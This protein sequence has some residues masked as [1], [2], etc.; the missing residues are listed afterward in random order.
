MK[1][2]LVLALIISFAGTNA[3]YAFKSEKTVLKAGTEQNVDKNDPKYNGKYKFKTEKI[4]PSQNKYEY[5]NMAWW[6]GF[7]DE[8]L[9]DVIKDFDD[10]G[11]ELSVDLS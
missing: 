2:I 7:N 10:L 8:Y 11:F 9:K 4:K 5:I 6:N 1:R 3:G